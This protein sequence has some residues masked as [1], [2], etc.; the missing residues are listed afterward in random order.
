MR[1]RLVRSLAFSI[2]TGTALLGVSFSMVVN[3]GSRP[4]LSQAYAKNPPPVGPWN[5][6]V[7]FPDGSQS[8]STLRFNPDGTLINYTP[9]HG[10]GT[11]SM[12]GSNQ[13]SY[14][15]EEQ[16]LDNQGKQIAYVDVQQQAAL[17]AS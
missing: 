1:S 16:I 15:F 11:W 7:T 12:T 13:F 8:L 4:P 2:V 5:L 17:S 10:T 6:M 9:G 14:Q 3:Q